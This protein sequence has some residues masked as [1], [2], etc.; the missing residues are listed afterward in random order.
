MTDVKDNYRNYALQL[1]AIANEVVNSKQLNLPPGTYTATQIHTA[2][3]KRN[4]NYFAKNI[5]MAECLKSDFSDNVDIWYKFKEVSDGYG[6]IFFPGGNVFKLISSY[7]KAAGWSGRKAHH[8]NIQESRTPVIET[9]ITFTSQNSM[10]KLAKIVSRMDVGLAKICIL[11]LV[12]GGLRGFCNAEYYERGKK[13]VAFNGS[14]FCKNP[15]EYGGMKAFKNLSF[16]IKAEQV[17]HLYGKC[18]IAP[19]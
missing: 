12:D 11:S 16:M 19:I 17:K 6:R 3:K 9:V 7:E 15:S 5:R 13:R 10:R 4:K 2:L 8:F 18:K 1:I 14:L